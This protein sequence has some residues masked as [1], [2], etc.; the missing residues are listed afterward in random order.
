ME[1]KSKILIIVLG[2]LLF[3]PLIDILLLLS[4]SPP[5]LPLPFFSPP[6]Y[7]SPPSLSP[8]KAKLLL[9]KKRYLEGLLTNT[10]TQLENLQQMVDNIEFTQIEVKVVEGLKQG[11]EALNQLHKVCCWLRESVGVCER[12][13][14]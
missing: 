11:N 14:K 2:E 3:H 6:P 1:R 13:F 10:D 5:P 8:R 9:K 4:L 7:L 12:V